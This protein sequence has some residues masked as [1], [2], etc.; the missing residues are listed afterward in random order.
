MCS[1]FCCGNVQKLVLL[2]SSYSFLKLP[3]QPPHCGF[4]S[5]AGLGYLC[6]VPQ[7]WKAILSVGPVFKAQ[8]TVYN[9]RIKLQ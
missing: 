7:S 4:L 1:P 5:N 9:E 8:H 2:P 6:Q 3:L